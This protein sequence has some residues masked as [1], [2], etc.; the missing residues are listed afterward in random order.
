[1]AILV[2]CQNFNFFHEYGQTVSNSLNPD[3]DPNCLQWL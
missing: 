3:L 2:V 1:M